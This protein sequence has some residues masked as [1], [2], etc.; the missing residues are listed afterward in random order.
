MHIY[1]CAKAPQPTLR[2]VPYARNAVR[3]SVNVAVLNVTLQEHR[4]FGE[5]MTSSLGKNRNKAPRL[6]KLV[7]KEKTKP[8]ALPDLVVQIITK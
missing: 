3:T 2:R 5:P 7:F 8:S 6:F 1:P 4:P